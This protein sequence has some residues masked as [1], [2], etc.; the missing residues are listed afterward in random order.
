MLRKSSGAPLSLIGL[1]VAVSIIPVATLVWLGWRLLN[2]DRIVERQQVQDQVENAADLVTAALQRA[3]FSSEQ[4]LAPDNLSWPD[5]AV[6]LV[7]GADRLQAYPAQRVAYLPVVPTLREAPERIFERGE[8]LEFQKHNLPA[9][10]NFYRSL[11]SSPDAAVRAGTLLRMARVLRASGQNERAVAAY[12]RVTTMDDVAVFGAPASLLAIYARCKVLEKQ[13]RWP[14]LHT[15]AQSL[16][17]GL[18]SARW[19]LTGSQYKLYV[20][21]VARWLGVAGPVARM[22]ELF[23]AAAEVLWRGRTSMPPSGQQALPLD[24]QNVAVL[25][26]STG[27][28]I[29]ALIASPQFVRQQWLPAI[30]A[31]V[32]DRDISWTLRDEDG[33]TL[34]GNSSLVT[35]TAVRRARDAGL[36]WMV[37]TAL[38]DPAAQEAQFVLRRRLLAAGL[39]LVVLMAIMAAYLIARSVIR[40]LAVARLQSDFVA[41]VSHEF[42]TQLTSLRQFTDLLRE[43]ATWSDER[44]QFCYEAQSRATGRLTRL[45]ESLLDFGRIEAGARPFTFEELDCSGLVRRVVDDFRLETRPAGYNIQFVGNGTARVNVDSEAISRALWNLLDNAVKYSPDDHFIEVEMTR[46]D[47]DIR[48]AVHDQGLGIPAH[49][50]AAIFGKFHRGEEARSRGIKGTGIGLTMAEHIVK[51]HRGSIEVESEPGKGSTFTIVLPVKANA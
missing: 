31:A 17:N 24:G 46:L 28:S 50:R 20:D 23:A 44:R 22:S 48:I 40:E 13:K 9:A 35:P 1:I 7:L 12:D 36:P 32:N 15:E 16:Q 34:F 29:H 18:Y 49:E 5:G 42:R 51:A 38:R 27:S 33:R 3:I 39:V 43:R 41:A 4:R 6:V 47:G 14:E 30:N 45:V 37:A 19:S 8:T 11:A 25:W 2:Q 26:Q 21:D 10:A